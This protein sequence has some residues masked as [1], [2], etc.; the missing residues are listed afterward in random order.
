MQR[1]TVKRG[2]LWRKS[3]REME[4]GRGQSDTRL[5]FLV[6]CALK[7]RPSSRWGVVSRPRIPTL[8]SRFQ[9][10]VASHCFINTPGKAEVTIQQCTIEYEPNKQTG[11]VA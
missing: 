6:F 5:K 9:R 11:V 8:A 1:Q 10:G 3:G 4:R 2:R 7:R